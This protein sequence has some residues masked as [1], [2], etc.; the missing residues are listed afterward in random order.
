MKKTYIRPEIELVF[1]APIMPV[2]GS[3][4]P[5]GTANT[6]FGSDLPSDQFGNEDWV[7]EGYKDFS[8]GYFDNFEDA[9]EIGGDDNGTIFSR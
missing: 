8:N 5:K 2:C 4:D 6:L 3:E 7:V 9:I 1:T